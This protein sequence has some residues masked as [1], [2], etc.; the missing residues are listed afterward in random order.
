MRYLLCFVALLLTVVSCAPLGQPGA[1]TRPGVASPSLTVTTFNLRVDTS[2]DGED[3]WD[4]RK[5]LALQTIRTLAPDILGTQESLPSQTHYLDQQLPDYTRIGV[6]RDDGK[7]GG[8]ACCLYLRR[9]RLELLD[10]GSFWLS[11]TPDVP[12]SKGWDAAYPRLVTWAQV[13]DRVTRKRMMVLTTHWDHVG[14]EARLQSAHLIRRWLVAHA[15]QEPVVILGDFNITETSPA[16]QVLVDPAERPLLSDAYRYL[17]PVREGNEGTFHGF[18]GMT[19]GP[20]IDYVLY[21]PHFTPVAVE[22]S[23]TSKQEH[24]P[25]DHFPFTAILAPGGL[26]GMNR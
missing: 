18:K 11:P 22:I 10:S 5:E 26:N 3:R 7:D 19:K 12:G 21:S 15:G 8:E 16:Y 6:G 4:L 2:A 17:H 25:S 1:A 14:K 24:Y 13:N 20:R 23:H 9:S